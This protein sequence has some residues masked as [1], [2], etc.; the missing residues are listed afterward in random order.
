MRTQ[1][2]TIPKLKGSYVALPRALIDLDAWHDLSVQGRLVLLVAAAMLPESS[3]GSLAAPLMATCSGLTREQAR[4]ALDELVATG[5]LF[6]VP[7]GFACPVLLDRLAGKQRGRVIGAVRGLSEDAQ[8]VLSSRWRW[9]LGKRAARETVENSGY[10]PPRARSCV[11][12]PNLTEPNTPPKAPPHR[13]GV[14][15]KWS[16][17]FDGKPPPEPRATHDPDKY[18]RAVLARATEGETP[19]DVRRMFTSWVAATDPDWGQRRSDGVGAFAAAA[20]RWIERRDIERQHRRNP[21]SQN[22]MQTPAPM[23]VS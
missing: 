12:E 22:D 7:E 2:N 5:F 20:G 13:R 6:P 18:R 1:S 14:V 17:A 15:E 10:A 16:G 11:T 9:V 21:V 8:S 3:V 4:A 19:E 23:T